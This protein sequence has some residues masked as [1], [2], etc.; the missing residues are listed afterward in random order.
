MRFFL[1]K[2]IKLFIVVSKLILLKFTLNIIKRAFYLLELPEF[3]INLFKKLIN[4]KEVV[5]LTTRNDPCDCDRFNLRKK[6]CCYKVLNFYY[7]L[8]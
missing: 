1:F 6:E 2:L 3:Q 5:M 4:S 7:V 8:K